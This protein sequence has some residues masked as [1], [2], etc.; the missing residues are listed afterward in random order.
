MNGFKQLIATNLMKIRHQCDMGM[1][2]SSL[3]FYDMKWLCPAD[4]THCSLHSLDRPVDSVSNS[5]V[6]MVSELIGVR[7]PSVTDA[8]I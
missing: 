8:R 4:L 6:S 1:L 7:L 3:V 2:K 5:P